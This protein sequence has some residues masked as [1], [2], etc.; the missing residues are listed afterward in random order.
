MQNEQVWRSANGG[1]AAT[2]GTRHGGHDAAGVN[3]AGAGR[4]TWLALL[5][6]APRIERE[7]GYAAASG[8]RIAGTPDAP[9]L[10]APSGGACY[11]DRTY[12]A[13][14]DRRNVADFAYSAKSA[15]FG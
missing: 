14:R 5:D 6:F 15:T 12:A 3:A 10:N 4:G 8:A 13:G 9:G 1:A 11:H 7:N 2:R